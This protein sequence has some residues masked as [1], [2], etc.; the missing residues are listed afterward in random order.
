MTRPRKRAAD[1]EQLGRRMRVSPTGRLSLPVEVRREVG[2]EN[3]G[4]VR[5]DV[6]DGAIRIRTMDA[7]R[8]KVRA[9][10]RA[11]GLSDKASVDGFLAYRAGERAA[12]TAGTKR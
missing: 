3:G 5:I 11:S 4:L 8:D 7:V 9:L 1:D 6:I 2:L 12:E 10:A